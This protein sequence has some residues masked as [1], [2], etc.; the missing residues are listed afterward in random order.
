MSRTSKY[1]PVVHQAEP[2]IRSG[3]SVSTYYT[4]SSSSSSVPR[5]DRSY[6]GQTTAREYGAKGHAMNVLTRGDVVVVN[7][8]QTG[9]DRAAPTPGYGNLYKS[10]KSSK[11]SSK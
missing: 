2:S 3:Y 5:S 1:M 7:R 8:N 9:Y 11:Y 6:H 10:S 4:S